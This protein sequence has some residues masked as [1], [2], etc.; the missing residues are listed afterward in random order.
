MHLVSTTFHPP[1]GVL[2]SLA[3]S[4]RGSEERYFVVLKTSSL[5]VF[6]LQ[7][8]GTELVCEKEIWGTP[9][10][11]GQLMFSKH[12]VLGLDIP[13]ARVLIL[14][15]NP[16][17]SEL[18]VHH[19]AIVSPLAHRP[20][21]SFNGILVSKQT[22]CAT[23]YNGHVKLLDIGSKHPYQ[24]KESDLRVHE[25]T[26]RTM[27]FTLPASESVLAIVFTDHHGRGRLIGR[28]ASTM[29]P[30]PQ[31]PE[32][33]LDNIPDLI[34]PVAIEDGSV[35]KACGVLLVA[36]KAI[37]FVKT[38]VNVY[39]DETPEQSSK[40]KDKV[41]ASRSKSEVKAAI[42]ASTVTVDV[43]FEDIAAWTQVDGTHLVVGDS[44]G[45]M[46]LLTLSMEPE[47]AMGV[48]TLGETSV[49]STLAYLSDNTF[50]VGSHSAP[51]QLVRI[52][53]N[54]VETKPGAQSKKKHP[55]DGVGHLE[56]MATHSDNLAPILDATLVDADGSGQSRIA[57]ISG[58]SS[59]GSLNIIH[60]GASFRETA[61][62]D[63]LANIDNLFPLKKYYD[64]AENAF[65]VATT[66]TT[67]YFFSISEAGFT[68]VAP[69]D[70]TG[71][72]RTARTIL[73]NNLALPGTDA[74]LHVTPNGA[75]VV[76]LVTGAGIS[77]WN[78]P[79]GDIIAAAVDPSTSIACVATSD[80]TL[81]CL[82]IQ[83]ADLVRTSNHNFRNKVHSQIS[84]LSISGNMV[85]VSF[86]G[87]NEILF[88]SLPTLQTI[89]PKPLV[90]T[91]SA[92]S[93]LLS[94]LGGTQLYAL[95]ACIDGLLIT[96]A[97]S[98]TGVP[99]PG[100]RRS[101]PLGGGPIHLTFVPAHGSSGARIVAAGKRAVA[102]SIINGRLA[103]SALP[104]TDVCAISSLDAPGTG[105]S[106]VYATATGL[107]FGQIEQLDKLNI[108]SFNLG[109]DS[110]LR[111]AHHSGL[112]IY[113][114]GCMRT[115]SEA[116]ND[117]YSVRF[118][119]DSTFKDLGRFELKHGEIVTSIAAYTHSELSCVLVGTAIFRPGENEARSGR[120][121][122]FKANPETG[123]FRME[124]SK[125]V[126]GEV[127][128]IKQLRQ[129][130]IACI[131]YGVYVFD[132][133][134][135]GLGISEPIAKWE[136]GYQMDDVV[137]RGQI[138]VVSDRL[139]SVSV[140]RLVQEV[141]NTSDDEDEPMDVDDQNPSVHFETIAMDMHAVWP[142]SIGILDD[143]KTIIAAQLDG[144]ILTWE[145]DGDKL[146]PRAAYYVGE[147]I[148]RFIII[149]SRTS[150]G[151]RPVAFFVTNGG[152]IGTLS[153]IE[154][155]D[156]LQLTRLELKMDN[157]IKGLGDINHADWRAPKRLSSSVKPPPRRGVTDGD[158]IKKFLELDDTTAKKVLS[159]GSAAEKIGTVEE[160]QIRRCLEAL[161]TDQ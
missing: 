81:H 136:R 2:Y 120:I 75:S 9:K 149:P 80:G 125:N 19:T 5:Q 29:N 18:A 58:D 74:V 6:V 160:E 34:I 148:N 139:R 129:R 68:F 45:R 39:A 25:L 83:P 51:S 62:L 153:T 49:P 56:I 28:T 63:G 91:S 12:L 32:K 85:L 8:H 14:D 38:N 1:S 86:W 130:I 65:L 108:N 145:V 109:S 143:D 21:L 92:S 52:S 95:L 50:Y 61:I 70:F 131:N 57:S 77:S 71:I 13:Q 33:E 44:F 103:V 69:G 35:D 113:A 53:E 41:K 118:M 133:A 48:V 102:L 60:K 157:A 155:D 96:H 89:E 76:D 78:P 59:G 116:S 134:Q 147:V 126:E 140:L 152:R 72:S 94:D 31:I 27:C 79:K 73:I 150:T 7:P 144:N 159:E 138:I 46:Y 121:L 106:V 122:A 42:Q 17:R 22:V 93:I 100:S 82:S 20:S 97:V 15:F 119:D 104:I 142:T 101:I 36:R 99:L 135:E 110:P 105:R 123:M 87:S 128:S 84:A 11:L 90:E 112:S 88:M 66:A 23:F 40:G 161:S 124:S 24:V 26:I 151:P 107:V 117:K 141:V 43:P 3:C 154:D 111:L 114:V 47:F 115:A 10:G 156:A 4:F 137:I 54:I 37:T 67:T 132:L 146:E 158:F 127:A 64:A 98:S 30:A 16:E 55:G